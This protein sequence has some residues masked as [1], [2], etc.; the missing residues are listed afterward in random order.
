MGGE[1]GG[2]VGRGGVQRISLLVVC[3]IE[4]LRKYYAIIEFN[5]LIKF[6]IKMLVVPSIYYSIYFIGKCMKIT[7]IC[8]I[9]II[10][11]I[12]ISS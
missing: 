10:E 5:V 7:I 2:W 9:Y 6:V 8:D 3:S 4:L 11:S 1:G 12:I